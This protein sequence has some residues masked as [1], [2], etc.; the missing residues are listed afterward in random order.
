VYISNYKPRNQVKA[1]TSAHAKAT[2]TQQKL[3]FLEMKNLSDENGLFRFYFVPN[4]IVLL[5]KNAFLRKKAYIKG[6][7]SSFL[8]LQQL[9]L[10]SS[11]HMP[12]PPLFRQ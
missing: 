3:V 10:Y 9:L 2:N 8:S 6:P 7:F 1:V 4:Q 12:I 5:P 11:T